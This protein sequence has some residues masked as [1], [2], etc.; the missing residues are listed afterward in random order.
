MVIK[1]T[2]VHSGWSYGNGDDQYGNESLGSTETA[3]NLEKLVKKTMK[4]KKNKYDEKMCSRQ[5]ELQH[6]NEQGWTTIDKKSKRKPNSTN[7][8]S[9]TIDSIISSID[10]EFNIDKNGTLEASIDSPT[11]KNWCVVPDKKVYDTTKTYQAHK[12]ERSP[13]TT[14][15]DKRK[16]RNNKQ[17]HTK[18]NNKDNKLQTRKRTRRRRRNRK[19]LRHTKK[20]QDNNK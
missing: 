20:K 12:Q 6:T 7:N 14:D 19:T 13:V 10:I 9:T 1:P 11:R 16:E 17:E 3:I 4:N 8:K 18:N 2:F 5:E 15:D